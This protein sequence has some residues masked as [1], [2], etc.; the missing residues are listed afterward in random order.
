M[1]QRAST[2]VHGTWNPRF[3][4]VVDEFRQNFA[5]RGEIGACLTV[6]HDG[7]P[8][9][10]VWAGHA[11]P[12]RTRPWERDTPVC[13]FS[14]TKGV[15]ALC[16]HLLADRG[17]LDFDAPV[18]R[19][20]PEFAAAGKERISVRS[21]LAHQ[22]GLAATPRPVTL[23][24]VC[25]WERM[26]TMLAAMRPWWEPGTLSCYHANTFGWL[27]GEVI[28]RISGLPVSEFV[29]RE[30]AG[31]LGLDFF[32]GLPPAERTRAAE[33]DEEH[34]A[35][36]DMQRTENIPDVVAAML[37]GPW[38]LPYASR[39]A[40]QA[41]EIPAVNGHGTARSL[42]R[43]YAALACD[44][45]VDGIRILSGRPAVDR[46]RE[47]QGRMH[48]LFINMA[49]P[50]FPMEWGLGYT[51]NIGGHYGPNRRA[52]GFTGYGGSFG[53][54]DPEARLS[55]AYATNL[56][57]WPA[58]SLQGDPRTRTLVDTTYGC[59]SSLSKTLPG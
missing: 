54:A 40:W 56:L 22:A 29:Q 1:S 31:P 21:V 53:F 4:P 19:Y 25:D 30:L 13:V 35:V 6:Y 44:G 7:T 28:R 10:D 23:E 17:E 3:A 27:V 45:E 32:I 33:L 48:D 36:A 24:D 26:T 50:D 46:C 47:G 8:V 43:V 39:P 38:G 57:R 59:L 52:F 11:D 34:P 42:A 12:G 51:L 41:A 20:W 18:A 9:V 15:T 49:A 37:A 55:M 16:A 14:A 58:D 2:A 5:R